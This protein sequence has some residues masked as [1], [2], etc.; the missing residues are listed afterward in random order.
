MIEVLEL[1]CTC[2]SG[3]EGSIDSRGVTAYKKAWNELHSGE[4]HASCSRE[5]AAK[6][7]EEIDGSAPWA[8]SEAGDKDLAK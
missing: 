1:Y 4:G 7:C 5:I 2:G 3:M 8:R 6:R